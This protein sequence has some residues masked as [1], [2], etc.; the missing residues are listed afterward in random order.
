LIFKSIS[1]N[2]ISGSSMLL[3]KIERRIDKK[4][5]NS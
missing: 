2:T 1:E 3:A 5:L 4:R